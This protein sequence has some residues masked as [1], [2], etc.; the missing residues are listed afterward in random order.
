VKRRGLVLLALTLGALLATHATFASDTSDDWLPHPHGATWTYKW[1]DSVYAPTP[2]L[3]KVTVKKAS[4]QNFILAWT[5]S[6]LDNPDSAVSSTGTVSFQ[7][8]D[9]G[10]VNTN[11]SSGPPPSNFPVLCA[12]EA[13]CGNSLASTYYNVIW[14][15]R[16]PV[17]AEPLLKGITWAGSGGSQNDVSSTSTYLGQQQVT[18]PAFSHPLTAAV[19]RSQI[20]QAGAIGDPYGSG[21]RTTWWVY[22]V[23]PVK[24]V[25][26]HAGGTGAPIMQSALQSTNLAPARTPTDLDYFP[27]V[28][29]RTLTYEWTNTKHLPKP[30]IETLAVDAVV[31]NTARFTIKK[32]TGPIRVKGSYGYSK[33]VEGV[34][35]LWGNTASAATTTQPQLGPAGAPANSRNHFASPF[36]LMDFGFNP[37]LTAYPGAG[38]T[39]GSSRSSSE[40]TTYGVTG[41]ATVLGIQT[42]HVPAGTF[43]ALAVRSKLLQPGFPYGSG[44]RTCWFAPGRG[45]VKLVFDHGDHSVSTVVLLK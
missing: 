24:V 36:D 6:G 43:Q 25:F 5:T 37:I 22:G 17:L 30:E 11:W 27:L 41:T 33:R 29:G 8:S 3:E 20:T 32:A 15:S 38:Q 28:K 14:G 19:V 7:D 21:I 13:S 16:N 1:T 23:G 10:I 12:Q 39:W 40:F 18:V 26:Q 45:L 34:T 31:N 2:T 35:N 42:I 9:E 44:T 4:G